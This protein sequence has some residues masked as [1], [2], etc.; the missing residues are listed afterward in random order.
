[1]LLTLRFESWPK[2]VNNYKQ[3]TI[4]LVG[5][6]YKLYIFLAIRVLKTRFWAPKSSF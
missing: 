4:Q 5:A 6:G 1:M 3:E 2:W